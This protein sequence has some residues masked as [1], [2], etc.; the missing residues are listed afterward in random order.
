MSSTPPPP[1]PTAGSVPAPVMVVPQSNGLA[2]SGFVVS[3]I[4]LVFSIIPVIG[5]IAWILAPIGVVL[6]AVGISAAG[7]N[8]G[9]GKGLAI[10]GLVLGMVALA[11]CV[12]WVVGLSSASSTS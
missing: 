7:K 2:T 11:I 3:L 6:S 10:A 4:G 12:L 1:P 5:V 9:V 8:G